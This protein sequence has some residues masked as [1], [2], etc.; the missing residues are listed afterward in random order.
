MV[1]ATIDDLE[2]IEIQGVKLPL[3]PEVMSPTLI[4]ALR[5]GEYERAEGKKLAK[6]IEPGERVLELGAGIGFLSSLVAATGQAEKIVA[7]EANPALIPLMRRT[8]ALNGVGAE[9]VH[10]AVVGEKTSDTVRFTL[11]EDFWAS[12]IKPKKRQ[13]LRGFV[14]V[15]TAA[16]GDLIRDH[17]PSFL[18]IDIEGGETDLLPH[19][20]LSGVRRAVME[21]HLKEIGH[22]GVAAVFDCFAR[23]GLG[24]DMRF[25][26]GGLVVFSRLA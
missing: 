5:T 13:Y 7:V 19:L 25:S 16:I 10:A 11:D 12:S 21:L 18:I 24:Y 4:E 6:M 15:P 20:D 9:V 3:D 22:R 17:G 23:Q 8:H 14:D 26:M 2:I 1:A